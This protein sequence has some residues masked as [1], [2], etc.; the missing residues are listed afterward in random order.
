MLKKD[1][2]KA[3]LETKEK[4]ENILVEQQIIKNRIRSIF[5]SGS[6]MKYFHG[7]PKKKKLEYS[8]LLI[9]EIQELNSLGLINE[10]DFSFMDIL[11][12]LFGRAFGGVIETAA[13][14]I[15]GS[16]LSKIG[17]KSDGFMKKFMVSLLT[18]KPSDLIKA[19]GDCKVLTKL[20]VESFVEA[21]VMLLQKE[22]N[23]DS[24]MFNTIRNT[25]G[26]VLKD[27]TFI[28]SIESKIES[29]VCDMF[30]TFTDKA[31]DVADKLKGE[32]SSTAST[33][34]TQS[35]SGGLFGGL[36]GK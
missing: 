23:A 3:L 10:Q 21:N 20:L 28:S 30:S 13:E 7:L 27:T 12:G 8:I 34:G 6:D 24:F 1:I 26:G 32:T 2:K 19:F 5:E 15:V 14:P 11:K 29:S 25:V 33:S 16:I 4:K 18:S 17:F 31:K 35:G 22:V 36:F 9:K